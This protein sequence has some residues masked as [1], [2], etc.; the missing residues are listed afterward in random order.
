MNK[1]NV[2][3]FVYFSMSAHIHLKILTIHIFLSG[4]VYYLKV[5]AI[6]N[7]ICIV[8]IVIEKFFFFFFDLVINLDC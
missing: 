1:E 2:A 7:I 5:D 3:K 8:K 4:I 6:P